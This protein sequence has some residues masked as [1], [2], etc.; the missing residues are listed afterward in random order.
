MDLRKDE[1]LR[2][3][4]IASAVDAGVAGAGEA[5]AMAATAPAATT[6]GPE[7]AARIDTV[8]ADAAARFE[9]HF[10]WRSFPVE[11]RKGA[12][13]S[14]VA[15]LAGG[16]EL[17]GASME[18]H[19]AGCSEVAL[20]AVTLGP[21]PERAQLACGGKPLDALI[22]DACANE[23]V[24]LGADAAE[25]AII[26]AAAE[27]GLATTWRFSPGY[28][29]LPLAVQPALLQAL[30]AGKRLN[31][32]LTPQMMMVP[33]KSVTAVIGLFDP[34]AVAGVAAAAQKC[35]E[36]GELDGATEEGAQAALTLGKGLG[37]AMRTSTGITTP[38]DT[39]PQRSSCA[40][41]A[42]NTPCW[43]K[44]VRR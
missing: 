7:L 5:G 20:L 6:L 26:A 35:G 17:P 22:Y 44:K 13:S 41:R 18:A 31:L 19:L 3:M 40:L 23:A 2:Y 15:R 37:T 14:F 29:D 8:M 27:R 28:G 30:D 9:P 1:V 38:C 34:A 10:V 42:A 11:E 33:S 39:C 16:L 32:R 12:G 36:A 4:G 43:Q 24:E 21:E 25:D